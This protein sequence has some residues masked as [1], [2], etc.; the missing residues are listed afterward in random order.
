MSKLPLIGVL[1]CLLTLNFAVFGAAHAAEPGAFVVKQIKVAGI[2]RISKN[3]VLTYM[4]QINVGQSVTPSQVAQAIKSLYQTGFFSRIKILRHHHTL[5]VD[6][7][8]RPTIAQ[9]VLSGNHAIKTKD[10]KKGLQQAG[11][12][13]GRFFDRAALD[14]IEQ[15]LIQ[16]YFNHGRYGVR[17]HPTVKQL[18]N[19]RVAIHLKIKEGSEAR[20]YSINL[21]GNHAFSKSTLLS[22]FKITTPGWFTW[23]SGKDKYAES[24]LRGS[25]EALRSF[26]MNRGYANFHLRSVQVSISPNKSHIYINVNL[27]EGAKYTIGKI[28]LLGQFPVPEKDLKKLIFIKPGTTFSMQLANAQS[29]ALEDR[30]SES[31]FGFAKVN[32][33][34]Q[35]NAK[36]HKVDLIF[37]INPGQRMYVRHIVFSGGSGTNDAVFR[38]EMRQFEGTWLSSTNMKRSRIRI[39][40]LPFV[41][42]V[43]I[44][45]KRVPGSKDL[46]DLH[47]K[48]H[49]RQSGT[50]NVYAAY[51]G[52]YGFT[53]G[54][55]VALADF[56]GSGK[57]VRINASRG[58]IQTN[59]SVDYVNPYATVYGVQRT[60][61]IFYQRS[62]GLVLNAST[63][64]SKDYGG[65][66]NYEFPISEFD[67]YTLGA[68]I[69]HEDL[70]SGCGSPVQYLNYLNNP[71][72]GKLTEIPSYCSGL[73]PTVPVNR[74]LPQLTYN[75]LDVNFG[76]QHDTRNRTVLPTRGTLQQLNLK[77]AVPPGQQRYYVLTWNQ[78]TFVPIA[79]GF[80]FGINSLVGDAHAYGRTAAVPP[81]EHFFAGGPDSVAGYETDWLG[82]RD[83]NGNPYGGD[84]VA[85]AQNELILPNIMGG[86]QAKH[87]YRLAL[88]FDVGN[89][90]ATPSDFT[91]SF[92][93]GFS[94]FKNAMRASYG[95]GLSWLTPLGEL[96][97]SYA[98][99]IWEHPG[100]KT[101]R[102]QFTLGAYF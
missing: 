30:L 87:S 17:I 19:N 60:L 15:Q 47:V 51:S 94:G 81:Y 88:F 12:T 48:I 50:A 57:T 55:Q 44:K 96:H 52:T 90:F 53:L 102:F 23:L 16:L 69:R 78:M 6:V 10:L 95:I 99:P 67:A 68:T 89:V 71:D 85:Y 61:R 42:T 40:R 8:E 64:N 91:S 75:N 83:S 70:Y 4:P 100:D 26:Y 74:L 28:K 86:E 31:G 46:V 35:P 43:K 93:N 21:V 56:L 49:E 65:T 72:N 66:V 36:T 73:D 7:K 1:F 29:Q 24:K 38:R 80:T 11:L 32:P 34:P 79:D 2:Q 3:T 82:P 97:F 33:I 84:F 54:G 20:V 41:D 58:P 76:F 39:Q 45:P 13:K 14:A 37:Y 18:P 5:I 101:S 92:K 77:V 25:L 22:K 27:H 9:V 62:S 63:F 59:M 98:F